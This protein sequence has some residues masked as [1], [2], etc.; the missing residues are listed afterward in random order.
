MPTI[1]Y[2][3]DNSENRLLISRILMAEDYDMVEA[4]TGNKGFDLAKEVI[5]D[6]ILMDINLPDIDGYTCTAKIRKEE[7][8]KHI[9][10]IALTA[11]AM[12][13]DKEK[14]LEAGCDGYITK[15]VDIDALPSVIERHMKKVR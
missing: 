2:I 5:P 8:I 7:T 10:I 3:D 1:L 6:L 4:D 13:G 12:V 11:N 15:P 9:P 14:A